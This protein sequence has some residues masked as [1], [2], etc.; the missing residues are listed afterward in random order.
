LS[1]A[2]PLPPQPLF[3]VAVEGAWCRFAVRFNDLPVARFDA[4]TTTIDTEVPINPSLVAGPNTLTVTVL[5]GERD[6]DAR[7]PVPLSHPGSRLVAEVT[8]RSLGAPGGTR[9]RL[10]GIARE[11]GV[12]AALDADADAPVAGP[13]G[14][15]TVLTD[16]D[17]QKVARQVL[18]PQCPYPSWLW[19][20]AEP[21]GLDDVTAAELIA[22]YRRLWATLAARDEAGL[23]ALLLD[24][25]REV[26][27]AF[28]LPTLHDAW[29]MLSFE[30]LVRRPSIS[31]LPMDVEGLRVELLAEGR[32]A[33]LTA[34]DGRS[35]IRLH[36]A[37]LGAE[38]AVSALF[39]RVTGRGWVQIR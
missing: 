2:P 19:T 7:S 20:R 35:A 38:G 27:T 21:L 4:S 15:V 36:D 14:A 8:V 3:S 32:V 34:P 6:D 10:G 22:Q 39:C 18:L 5:P 9:K 11:A 33:R 37:E 24:N 25:A 30:D 1:N 17:E 31:V 12:F 29:R 23:R 26:Q 28:G 16:A 13:A